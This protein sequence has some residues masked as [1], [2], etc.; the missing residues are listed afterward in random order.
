MNRTELIEFVAEKA[1]LTK[2]AADRALNAFVD[3]V[4]VSLKKGIPVVMVNFGKFHVKDRAAREGRN[5]KTGEK[6]KI[7]ATKAVSFK[8]GKA[9][10]DAVKEGM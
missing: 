8:A 1:G 3:G 6:I 2:E 10:K 7:K 4:I 5:L 9:L